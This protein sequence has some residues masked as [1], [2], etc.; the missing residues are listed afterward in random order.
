MNR[1]K[2]WTTKTPRKQKWGAEVTNKILASHSIHHEPQKKAIFNIMG[3]LG[4][5]SGGNIIVCPP[6]PDTWKVACCLP[7]VLASLSLLD[8]YRTHS[9][10]FRKPVLMLAHSETFDYLEDKMSTQSLDGIT[11]HLKK[12]GILSSSD[13]KKGAFYRT[14]TLKTPL[15]AAR[16]KEAT[17][18]Y[19]VIL[20]DMLFLPQLP[21]DKFSAIFI[22]ASNQL[23]PEKLRPV[24]RRFG[25]DIPIFLFNRSHP[26][27]RTAAESTGPPQ[28]EVQNESKA[29]AGLS[30]RPKRW[31][32]TVK[33][34]IHDR[35]ELQP[36][37]GSSSESD[38]ELSIRSSI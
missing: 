22:H 16:V 30:L 29:C 25:E 33:I 9:K 38:L 28:L 36:L 11:A 35:S 20:A 15:D 10:D 3:A 17:S 24:Q 8:E 19:D 21:R 6:V 2:K 1:L 37:I 5:P 18:S 27:Y 34:R 31:K 4:N 12:N 32:R 26:R 7:Y 14:F 23:S 13:L